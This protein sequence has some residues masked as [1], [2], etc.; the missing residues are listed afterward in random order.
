VVGGGE[1]AIQPI[2]R[3]RRVGATR[4]LYGLVG[5]AAALMLLLGGAVTTR[6]GAAAWLDA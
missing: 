1:L 6:R 2:V 5:G 4:W 3:P